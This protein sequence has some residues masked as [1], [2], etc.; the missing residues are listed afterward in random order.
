MKYILLAGCG[1]VAA[2]LL[3][4]CSTMSK[5]ECLAG[6]W[7]EKGYA[8][9]AAGYPV[10]RL[11]DHAK[12]CEKYQVSPNP[13]AYQSA[14]EDGLRTYCTFQRGWTEGRAGNTY[15]GVCRSEEEAEFLPAY[16]DGRHL[17][18]AE[19]AVENAESALNSAEAR[20]EDR[21]DKLDAKQR[22]LRQD[23]LT[24]EERDRIRDRIDE[25]R[26]EIRDAR[27]NAREASDVLDRARWDLDRVRRELSG[28]YPVY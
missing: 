17:H 18:E 7:G 25:V 11:D 21:E 16:N 14:R 2:A 22:E 10:S 15:Y 19:A 3:S 6:A 5:D 12:A 26:G 4:S 28:R 13:T 23:G 9:G 27:R 1:F 20:I 8:D 24:D